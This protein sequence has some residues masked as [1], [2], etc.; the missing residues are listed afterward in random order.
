[1]SQFDAERGIQNIV[2]ELVQECTRRGHVL[3]ET[4]VT[5]MVK[6]VVVDPTN[7]FENER[8]LTEQ[9]VEKL[10]QLCLEKL[11][12]KN[13]P[14]LDSIKMQLYFCMNYISQREFLKEIHV[15]LDSRLSPLSQQI[16]DC[17]VKTSRESDAVYSRII[18]Y[19]L[20]Q[21][22]MGSPT[23]VDSVQEVKA[24]LQ[25]IFPQSE[26]RSFMILPKKKKEE[27]LQE[28][29]MIST[30]IRLFNNA[31]QNRE[32]EFDIRELMPTVLK[33]A[34][35][36]TGETIRKELS[37]TRT[38][39]WKFTAVLEKLTQRSRQSRRSEDPV[40]LLR[41]ALY[42]V[43]AHE[44]FLKV[45][46]TDAF[47]CEK[48]VE[49]LQ[50]DLSSQLKILTETLKPSETP[51]AQRVISSF[52]AL[53]STWSR[54]LDEA[55][56]LNFLHNITV[57]LRPFVAS[58]A[59][60]EADLDG[61]QGAAEVK[62]D[63]Q[64]LAE[65]S[66][67]QIDPAQA[68][69]KEWLMPEAASSYSDLPLQYNGFCGSTLVS[70]DG[71]LLPGNPH[72]GVLKHEGKLY[73]FSSKQAA[74]KFASSPDAFAAEVVEKAKRSPELIH[75]LNLHQQLSY[76]SLNSVVKTEENV[77]TK[78]SCKCDSGTQT[79]IHPV[80]ANIDKSYEWNEWEL[81]RKALQLV[82]LRKKVTHSSQTNQSHMRRE[83]ATQTWLQ[84][85][86]ACQSK[87][88]GGSSA[89]V[90]HVYLAGLIGQKEAHVVKVNLSKPAYAE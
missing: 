16:T 69:T 17:R 36:S 21:S 2:G 26:L 70:S 54:L 10:K 37:E 85:D 23:D 24:A 27:Q 84:K 44:G 58:R 60:S 45:L 83:N 29:A 66:G 7:G 86:A 38:L 53:S 65:S 61:L 68:E 80:E 89:T 19:I 4:L 25:S 73:A 48:V 40:V 8:K 11:L 76:L 64:R 15:S 88:D 6:A 32:G 71:L 87:R 22:S 55:Q 90:P 47:S 1:M 78:S 43:R 35:S 49:L 30:G 34:L 81:R 77:R 31:S 20:L 62:S 33:D 74:L 50:T 63:E 56:L 39:A 28:L 18:T 82:N 42:N 13:S 46:L 67:E 59:G 12:E 51:P 79:D 14:S 52:K 72:I 75:L 3:T 41:Q 57:N 5:F 9:D